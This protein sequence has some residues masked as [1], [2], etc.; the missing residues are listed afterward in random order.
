MR[1]KKVKDLLI[2]ILK[3]TPLIQAACQKAEIS[4]ST[5]YRWMATDEDFSIKVKMAMSEGRK[6]IN[7]YAKSQVISKI[8]E[9]NLTACFYWLNHNDKRF[10]NKIE[11][12][13]KI[14]TIKR[15][16]PDQEEKIER[17][18]KYLLPTEVLKMNEK[19]NHEES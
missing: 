12:G 9:G 11:I 6:I 16:S 17:A 10:M 15:L 14:E 7:D 2:E 18:I 19:Q 5:F 4:R 3:K 1:D 8:K 13:G